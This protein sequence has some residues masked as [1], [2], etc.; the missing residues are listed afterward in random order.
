MDSFPSQMIQMKMFTLKVYENSS[1]SMRHI[2]NQNSGKSGIPNF[3]FPFDYFWSKRKLGRSKARLPRC[4]G[5]EVL[6]V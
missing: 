4:L 3:H 1:I 6:L 5:C 2:K